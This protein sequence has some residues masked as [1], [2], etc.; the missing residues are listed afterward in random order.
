MSHAL[1]SK[2]HILSRKLQAS[3]TSLTVYPFGA[4]TAEAREPSRK[5]R[6]LTQLHR[7]RKLRST[8]EAAAATLTLQHTPTVAVT[9]PVALT[10]LQPHG[11]ITPQL[12]R[13]QQALEL[14]RSH[15][16]VVNELVTLTE[17][18]KG[19]YTLDSYDGYTQEEARED[20]ERK[21]EVE[22]SR[23]IVAEQLRLF[24]AE[25]ASSSKEGEVDEDVKVSAVLLPERGVEGREEANRMPPLPLPL[26]LPPPP[27]QS[28][29]IGP[30]MDFIGRSS[31]TTTPPAAA[32]AATTEREPLSDD[33]PPPEHDE[34]NGTSD[35]YDQDE[36]YDD[37]HERQEEDNTDSPLELDN[38]D[39]ESSSEDGYEVLS[40]LSSVNKRMHTHRGP[41]PTVEAA[42]QP[43]K[44]D[45]RTHDYA[46]P[47]QHN[48][49]NN[50][51]HSTHSSERS[52]RK[53]ERKSWSNNTGTSSSSSVRVSVSMKRQKIISDEEEYE[54][55]VSTKPSH[56]PK[57]SSSRSTNP[58]KKQ[59]SSSQTS[60]LAPSSPKHTPTEHAKTT[61]HSPPVKTTTTSHAT[62]ASTSRRR[63]K[64]KKKTSATSR[65][66]HDCKGVVTHYLRCHFWFMNGTKCGKIYCKLCLEA[67]YDLS[68]KVT[69]TSAND[70]LSKAHLSSDATNNND[71][72]VND[73]LPTS[74]FE[75]LV[76]NDEWHCPSCL[77]TCLCTVCVKERERNERRK[78]SIEK[79]RKSR[80]SHND[81]G[82]YA[83][84]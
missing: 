18:V 27:P 1:H 71:G 31:P 34:E 7:A 59:L 80:S 84:F 6:L 60:T 10:P 70:K 19:G 64:S 35:D 72:A 16:F 15:R 37:G 30:Y 73:V 78:A 13:K 23:A 62:S 12:H 55:S 36:E 63:S 4:L 65:K 69:V 57:H 79:R 75:T 74:T 24:V 51:N 49:N 28:S 17:A 48:T 5:Q 42:S 39:I 44:R 14:L 56:T 33:A 40:S 54:A 83:A 61:T 22:K 41:T 82:F 76:D 52:H 32:A 25:R 68:D 47:T 58:S 21:V 66:C 67:K 43:I 9:N 38:G 50:H 29:V 81:D 53:R 77:N 3:R 46:S 11:K 26:K 20:L 8:L 45:R 2:P